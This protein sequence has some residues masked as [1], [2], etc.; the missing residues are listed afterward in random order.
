MEQA[1]TEQLCART[2]THHKSHIHS[3]STELF[4]LSLWSARHSVWQLK[5]HKWRRE[6]GIA[7]S[8][9][10]WTTEEP[11]FDVRKPWSRPVP[12]SIQHSIQWLT[13]HFAPAV[14]QPGRKPITRLRKRRAK[15]SLPMAPWCDTKAHAY[16]LTIMSCCPSHIWGPKFGPLKF[17]VRVQSVKLYFT[18]T[19]YP[20]MDL[21]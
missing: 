10:C 12:G 13:C 18:V 5:L 21:Y 9:T 19:K 14:K 6:T 11:R 15:P 4:L 20:G 16:I 1:T 3:D 7:Q 2:K 8:A 17:W